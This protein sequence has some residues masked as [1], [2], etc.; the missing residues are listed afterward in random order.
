MQ[1]RTMRTLDAVIGPEDLLEAIELDPIVHLL[2]RMLAGEAQMV[3]RMAVLGGDYQP[4][5][6]TE[7]VRDRHH[8]IAVWHRQRASRT[9][10]VLQI[11]QN[12]SPLA[13]D[14]TPR[15]RSARAMIS[16]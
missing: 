2:A 8:G 16:R 7:R 5:A 14:F 3:R 9:E 12:Q 1:R 4:K 13:H 6:R 11:D 15:V 10:V